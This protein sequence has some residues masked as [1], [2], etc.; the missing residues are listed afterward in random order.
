MPLNLI[1]QKGHYKLFKEQALND[2][3]LSGRFMNNK[4][5]RKVVTTGKGLL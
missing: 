3:I 4:S 5:L 1:G 2:I